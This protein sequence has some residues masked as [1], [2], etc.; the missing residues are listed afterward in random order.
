MA[1]DRHKG[2]TVAICCHNSARR[3]PPTLAHLAAQVPPSTSWELLIIDNAST[4]DTASVAQA[5]WPADAPAPMR[6][7]PEPRLG[8]IYGR[9]RAFAEARYELICFIDDDNWVASDWIETVHQVMEEHPE[10]G[11]C[12]GFCV[13]EC[14]T[15][16]PKWFGEFRASYAISTERHLS[17]DITWSGAP[18]FGAGLTIRRPAW[19]QLRDAGF[20]FQLVGRQG[21]KV[22]SGEDE[23]LCLALRMVGWH[24]W[25]DPRLR[26][27][28]FI[29]SRRLNWQYCR[30]LY[31]GWGA[32]SVVLDLYE[33]ANYERAAPAGGKQ[34]SWIWQAIYAAEDLGRSPGRMFRALFSNE[35]GNRDRLWLDAKLGRLMTLLRLRNDYTLIRQRLLDAAWRNI[36]ISPCCAQRLG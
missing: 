31:R 3:L 27:R 7:I 29:E 15:V 32:A 33:P 8:L 28:H 20:E 12:N 30:K 4:D 18:L 36:R 22:T 25:R 9:L 10:V 5:A 11:A 16:P 14:E 13:A 35:E 34:E 21:R 1:A 23:E 2:I 17:G 24:W 19:E 26:F 6:V